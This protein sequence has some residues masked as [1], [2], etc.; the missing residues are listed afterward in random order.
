MTNFQLGIFC[1]VGAVATVLIGWLL[2]ALAKKI[3]KAKAK[4]FK[5]IM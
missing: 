2:I 4:V 1:L 5:T 3:C